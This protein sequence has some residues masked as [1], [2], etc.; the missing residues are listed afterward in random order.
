MK[1]MEKKAKKNEKICKKE[2]MERVL[3][4][5]Q[6]RNLFGKRGYTLSPLLP[7]K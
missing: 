2:E 3:P 1:K 7:N 4:P 6:T 5:P